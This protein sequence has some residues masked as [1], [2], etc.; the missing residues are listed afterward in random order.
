MRHQT[1]R[2]VFL[3]FFFLISIDSN[4]D[5][6]LGFSFRCISSIPVSNPPYPSN[7]Q[8]FHRCQ[9]QGKKVPLHH[10][11]P[12]G[13]LQILVWRTLWTWFLMGFCNKIVIFLLYT[14]NWKTLSIYI[15]IYIRG[16][17]RYP[18]GLNSKPFHGEKPQTPSRGTL[19][20]RYHFHIIHITI[21]WC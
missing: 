19:V 11:K 8:G 6:R 18:N 5:W 21:V 12:M 9:T 4:D 17:V 20:K 1:S 15:Y 10:R 13:L 14:F 2:N 7:S 16:F 3:C